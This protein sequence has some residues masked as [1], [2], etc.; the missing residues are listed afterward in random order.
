ML[1]CADAT[2]FP[3]MKRWLLV[4]YLLRQGIQQH[5]GWLASEPGKAVQR[6]ADL[7]RAKAPHMLG[8]HLNELVHQLRPFQLCMHTAS[9]GNNSLPRCF[10]KWCVHDCTV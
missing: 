2:C 3:S 6:K 7:C 8:S 5:C 9:S 10:A 4:V 1:A